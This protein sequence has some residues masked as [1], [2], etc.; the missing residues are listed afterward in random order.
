[1]T[2]AA[3]AANGTA[4]TA[5]SGVTTSASG[6][7]F[8]VGVS[9][10][11]SIGPNASSP[12]TDNKSNTYTALGTSGVGSN[13][14]VSWYIS[15]NASPA[16]GSNHQW[17]LTIGGTAGDCGIG[18]IEI[19]GLSQ[20]ADQAAS[21]N[22]NNFSTPGNSATSEN[23]PTNATTNANDIL[24]ALGSN[25]GD[26]TQTQAFSAHT[27]GG[28]YTIPTGGSSNN[29]TFSPT[30]MAYQ[31]VSATGSYSANYGTGAAGQSH[32]AEGL[33]SIE[34]ATGGGGA[35]YYPFISLLGVG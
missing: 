13:G 4:S 12:V 29:T 32:W 34:A 10:G 30:A 28:T 20:T 15:S 16:G 9:F 33:I 3:P 2:L 25:S 27:G 35:Q 18:A 14:A 8:L 6:S 19:T 26:N 24:L 31:I 21:A 1:M 17:T 5:A 7:V 11:P 22:Y 23:T